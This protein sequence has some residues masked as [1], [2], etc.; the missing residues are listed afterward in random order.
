MID[1]TTG[2]PELPA[3]FF[4]RITRGIG[5]EYVYLQIRQRRWYGSK[6]VA[7]SIIEKAEISVSEILWSANHALRKFDPSGSRH[8]QFVGDY[9]PN[10]LVVPDG[11]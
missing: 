7:A 3:G 10:T 1:E 2:L 11:D 4:W 9:P 6:K 5:S 8:K